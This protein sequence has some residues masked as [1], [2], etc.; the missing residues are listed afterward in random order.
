MHTAH[1]LHTDYG[2]LA[3]IN[4][5]N[6]MRIT[7]HMSEWIKNRI[8][9][10][11]INTIFQNVK[12]TYDWYIT[13]C[14][15]LF[16]LIFLIFDFCIFGKSGFDSNTSG[17][18]SNI[19]YPM[20]CGILSI[21]LWD[22]F[23]FYLNNLNKFLDRIK[24]GKANALFELLIFISPFIYIYALNSM[25][26]AGFNLICFIFGATFITEISNLVKECIEEHNNQ[27]N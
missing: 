1:T 13:V 3:V 27:F 25:S 8:I 6:N 14:F 16:G 5:R 12:I 9:N 19:I 23:K 11:F 24:E 22:I 18:F 10:P 7:K 4:E 15:Y 26:F 21:N 17:T 20:I 2:L